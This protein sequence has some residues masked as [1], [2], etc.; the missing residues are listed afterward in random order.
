MRDVLLLFLTWLVES[1]E[2]STVCW[3]SIHERYNTK[4]KKPIKTRRVKR[5][6]FVS[7]C[8]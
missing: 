7:Y 5:T 1:F 8:V 6:R 3:L 4:T 2:L